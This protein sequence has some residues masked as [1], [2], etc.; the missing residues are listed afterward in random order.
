MCK[1]SSPGIHLKC[2][3]K[4]KVLIIQQYWFITFAGIVVPLSM[5]HCIDELE[6]S[7]NA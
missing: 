3:G 4:V 6:E 5:K 7:I 2:L 1:Q